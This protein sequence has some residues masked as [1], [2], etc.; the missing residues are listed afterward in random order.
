MHYEARHLQ[1]QVWVGGVMFLLSYALMWLARFGA[2]GFRWK[3]A[4]RDVWWEVDARALRATGARS[5][6][7]KHMLPAI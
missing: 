6:G 5:S 4:Y 7:E 3:R 2:L 1:Q